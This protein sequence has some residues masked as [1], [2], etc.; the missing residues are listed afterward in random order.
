MIRKSPAF[1]GSQEIRLRRPI[2]VAGR[3][4]WLVQF[5]QQPPKRWDSRSERKLIETLS[6]YVREVVLRRDPSGEVVDLQNLEQPDLP[7]RGDDDRK[8]FSEKVAMIRSTIYT[9]LTQ[10]LS[11][12]ARRP[13]VSI[14][15]CLAV[16][17][18]GYLTKTLEADDIREALAY[19]L[20]LE[21][22]EFGRRLRR[23]DAHHCGRIFVRQRRQ[24]Y[25]SVPCRNRAT[26]RRW[27]R[28]HHNKTRRQRG[29][30]QARAL[31]LRR[32]APH[33]RLVL[34]A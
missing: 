21:I 3:L 5:A 32:K 26:F 33:R 14:R 2:P 29:V 1:K 25:C 9:M 7:L 19:V 18:D 30:N 13:A 12:E 4:R 34:R 24:R 31:F 16:D 15:L 11:D 23:C 22:K 28:R 6:S 27:Y 17:Q 8:S 20:I 10:H